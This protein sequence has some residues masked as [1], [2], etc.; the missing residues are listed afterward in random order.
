MKY[1]I[2]TEKMESAVNTLLES[3]YLAIVPRVMAGL[4]YYRR[5]EYVKYVKIVD[6]E[7]DLLGVTNSGYLTE[8]EIKISIS[9]LRADFKKKHSHGGDFIRNFYYAVPEYMLGKTLELIDKDAGI[10]V[11]SENEVGKRSS[12]NAKIYRKPKP[13]KKAK[14]LT[15]TMKAKLFRLGCIKY[16]S[17]ASKK[18]G[19][20]YQYEE[21]REK[22]NEK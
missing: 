8:I 22:Q 10:I 21:E 4:G 15:D 1:K 17:M 3:S 7:C 2:T 6:H 11:V 13:N 16:W 18:L 19:L 14:P 12:F 20:E 5:D 9:D